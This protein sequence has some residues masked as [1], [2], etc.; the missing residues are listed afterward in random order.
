MNPIHD[1]DVQLLLAVALASK[2]KPAT[3]D[4]VIVALALHDKRLPPKGKLH[5]AFTRL[6]AHGLLQQQDDGYT[7]T[8]AA[9]GVLEL[10]RKTYEHDERVFRVKERLAAFEAAGKHAVIQLAAEQLGTAIAS[11]EASLP[12]LTKTEKAE[13][14]REQS[15]QVRRPAA[16]RPAAARPRARR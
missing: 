12:P 7:L 6:S 11:Y 13:L 8:E 4:E 14:K 3:L 1:T 5:D 15:G 2:R 16:G 9:Q 10:G